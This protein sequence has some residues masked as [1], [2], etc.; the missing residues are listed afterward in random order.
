MSLLKSIATVSGG[1]A[2]SRVVG[3]IRDILIARFLGASMAADAFFVALRFPN[4]FR[5][6]FAE[7]TLNVAFVPLFTG[8]L[9]K[10]KKDAL[11]FAKAVFSFLFYV[12]LIFV[13]VMELLMPALMF[14][15]APGFDKIPGKLELTTTLSRITFPFLLFV[16]LVSL[17]AGVLNSVG[18]FWAAAFTPTILNLCMIGALL[19][20]VPFMTGETTP[21]YALAWG[22]TGAGVVELLF[23]GWHIKKAGY[24]FGLISPIKALFH[25]TKEV[26]TLLKRM[27]PGVLGSG[28]YQ[29]NLFLDTLFVSLVGAGA[30]SWLNYA[31][32][33]FQLPIGIIGV[34]I[35]TALLP[36][37]SHHIKSGERE[38][39]N[40]Q[41]NRGLELSI[42]M[43]G[44]S[45]IGLILLAEPIIR[46]LFEHG[47]FTAADTTHTARALIVF[48]IGLPA[49]MMTKALSP[50]FY[51]RGD[52]STPVKIAIVGVVLNAILALSLMPFLGYVGIALATGLTTWVNA[53][54]YWFRLRHNKE[55]SLD[56]LF[57][58]RFIRI[59]ISCIVMA[60][61]LM[62]G[63]WGLQFIPSVD[64]KIW[65]IL[66]LAV[67]VCAGGASFFITLLTTKAFSVKQMISLLKRPRGGKAHA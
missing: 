2:I 47:M 19:G 28:V 13:V 27:A 61:L 1:T 12:L 58:Y 30:M 50:F 45:M 48:A 56:N 34:A 24:L 52:T 62:V 9:H 51:A 7:G 35:G 17:L 33:L 53:A 4:L 49:Y 10:S 5:S 15:F 57:K 29:I 65:Q 3:F 32:H 25:M 26:K 38:Q 46:T 22:V 16:S 59:I 67:L 54:Q 11:N 40:T 37:L 63:R 36:V 23:L 41:L 31:Q 42:A 60:G 66:T 55:F 43:S 6:L 39:A 21:A 18:K 64:G 44:A 8:E 14:L 20:A